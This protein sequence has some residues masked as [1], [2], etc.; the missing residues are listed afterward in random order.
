MNL[1]CVE[2]N[3]CLS[4]LLM[5]LNDTGFLIFAGPLNVPRYLIIDFQ[6]KR[7]NRHQNHYHSLHYL[8]DLFL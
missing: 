4:N 7:Q 3:L 2:E 8:C 5:D 6:K 1:F